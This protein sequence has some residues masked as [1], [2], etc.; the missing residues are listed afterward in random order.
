M[1]TRYPGAFAKLSETPL[2]LDRA[3]PSLG[4]DQALLTELD[5]AAAPRRITP[6]ARYDGPRSDGAYAGLKVADFAWVG[7]GPL[8]SKSLADHGATVVHIET[9]TRPDVLRLAPPFKDNIP[10]STTPNSWPTSTPPSSASPC[11]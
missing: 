6:V 1:D 9:A 7:V 8:I 10:A 11:R 2:Q 3:A 5:R 4:Q